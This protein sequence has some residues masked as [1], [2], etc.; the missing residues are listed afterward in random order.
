MQDA[1]TG[2][3]YYRSLEMRIIKFRSW[4]EAD[5]CFYYFALGKYYNSEGDYVPEILFNWVNAEQFITF[6]KNVKEIYT[7]DIVKMVLSNAIGYI[8]YLNQCAG[9]RIVI[10]KTDLSLADFS[11]EVIGNIHEN[12][13]RK[14]V[15]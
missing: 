9:Y 1:L 14:S 7:G 13:D 6:D 11:V 2:K 10:K 4:D 3:E 8:I 5:K 15:V 12:S